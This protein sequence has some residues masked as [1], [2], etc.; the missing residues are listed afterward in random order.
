MKFEWLPPRQNPVVGEHEVHV[1][2]CDFRGIIDFQD[3]T[4]SLSAQE[5]ERA[6]R[7]KTEESRLTFV[8]SHIFLRQVLA[9]YLRIPPALVLFAADA[10]GK[11]CL[12]VSAHRDDVQFNLTHSHGSAACA[13]ARSLK[14]G[15]DMERPDSKLCDD[16]TAQQ[17]FG[18]EE[19]CQLRE[20]E[21]GERQAAFFRGWTKKEAY[22]KCIGVGLSVNLAGLQLGFADGRSTFGRYSL[23]TFSCPN[24][25][26]ATSAV[27]GVPAHVIFW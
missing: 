19:L 8:G 6:A 25:N 2:Y 11:P 15:I 3:A 17:V 21:P 12:D 10:N 18:P 16:A 5:R 27:E 1:W 26:V 7:F 14:V 20:R 24:Q 23:I 13:V 22:A 4:A 9:A